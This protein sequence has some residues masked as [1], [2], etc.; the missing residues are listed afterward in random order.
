MIDFHKYQIKISDEII[1]DYSIELSFF[2]NAFNFTPSDS[3]IQ[4]VKNAAL[5]YR[6]IPQ[7]EF[8]QRVFNLLRYLFSEKKKSGPKRQLDWQK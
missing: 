6:L 5:K 2:S 7:E 4:K 3:Y 1:F 8:E